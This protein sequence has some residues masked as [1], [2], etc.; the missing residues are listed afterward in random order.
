[1]KTVMIP[2]FMSPYKC[3]ING[4][5]YVYPAG[6]EQTVPDEVAALIEA[7]AAAT[8]YG[9]RPSAGGRYVDP[10]E[11][12]GL[13][14]G[15][16]VPPFAD[17][18]PEQI[19]WI[20]K[21]DDPSKYWSVGD[22]R[23][24]KI[25]LI[26]YDDAE[27]SVSGV[28]SPPT[29]VNVKGLLKYVEITQNGS[30]NWDYTDDGETEPYATLNGK[31]LNASEFDVCFSGDV[32]FDFIL[33]VSGIQ[34]ESDCYLSISGFNHDDVVN[35][36]AYGKQKAGLS[37]MVGAS[38]SVTTEYED[39]PEHPG[40]KRVKDIW[41]GVF[42][43]KISGLVDSNSDYERSNKGTTNY[44][45][46]V[47][48]RNNLQKVLDYFPE[49]APFVQPVVKYTAQYYNY[50]NRYTQWLLTEDKVFLP[51]E[52]ELFGEVVLSPNKEGEQ[53]ELFRL[54]ESKI[55]VTP[56]I[57]AGVK[58]GSNANSRLW[59]RSTAAQYVNLKL[60]PISNT[61]TPLS[62]LTD[63]SSRVGNDSDYNNSVYMSYNKDTKKYNYTPSV[64]H[65]NGSPTRHPA[66]ILPMFCL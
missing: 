31:T 45:L 50:S 24:K 12:S 46:N 6:T 27:I 57:A 7:N 33:N 5:T 2:T 51:S 36:S 43:P 9:K 1:M 37:L 11:A 14:P 62:P 20:S 32:S 58:A 40:E 30:Y 48:Y 41:P 49:F 63:N 54:G 22:Y 42:L 38:R 21:N 61:Y 65:S 29:C 23:V 59:L 4:V 13:F 39:D 10:M 56:E 60:P 44:E 15:R 16:V 53:Y 64:A 3:T 28:P 25:P 52:Y 19:A 35:K 47:A 8:D 34:A 66:Y 17:A 18:T 55:I 26:N